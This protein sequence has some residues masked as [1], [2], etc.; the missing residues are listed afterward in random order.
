MLQPSD[1]HVIAVISNPVRYKSRVRLFKEF[2]ERMKK[3]GCTLWV[4]EAVFG[5]RDHEV[6][7]PDNPRHIQLRCDHE[8]WIK[9]AMINAAAARLPLSAKYIGWIDADV[10]HVREDWVME[11]LH[12]LQHHNVVQSFSHAC[13]LDQHH[14]PMQQHRGFCFRHRT[15][16]GRPDHHYNGPDMHPG[17]CWFWRRECWDA[18]GG[19]IDFAIAGAG[20]RHMAMA[21]VG[22]GKHSVTPGLHPSYM[23]K[24]LEW[25]HRALESVKRNIGY[26]PGLL[27]HH[28]HGH[29]VDRRYHDRWQILQRNEFNPDR[30]ITRD[31]QG[32]IRL[33]S[34]KHQLRDD[35]QRYFR[36]RNEDAA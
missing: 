2:E 19:M 35:L 21:L 11:V 26:V 34:E 10:H 16:G 36:E 20:D 14:A 9:E 24:V 30:D 17:Y 27:L 28:F 4:V 29:K 33:R 6:T 32:M 12:A 3:T 7:D 13:D 15:E 22:A 25:E 31:S 8:V 1:L 18:V 23:R 5:E